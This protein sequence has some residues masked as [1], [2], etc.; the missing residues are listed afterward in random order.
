MQISW[1]LFL[2]ST[3]SAVLISL[4]YWITF[5]SDGEIFSLP[6]NLHEHLFNILPGLIDLFITGIPVRIYQF[7]YLL[8]F[9]VVYCIFTAI[10]YAAGGTNS[11]GN[12]YVYSLFDYGNSPIVSSFAVIIFSFVIPPLLHLIFWG[13]YLFRTLLLDLL[14]TRRSSAIQRNESHVG[15]ANNNNNNNIAVV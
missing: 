5:S 12:S 6:V 2:L 3:E 11:D 1:I 10:F 7:I 15:L 4:F 8:A 13:L 14:L 9:N